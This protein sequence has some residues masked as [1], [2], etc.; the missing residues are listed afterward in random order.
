MLYYKFPTNLSQ[1]FVNLSDYTRT[2][3]MPVFKGSDDNGYSWKDN[4][5]EQYWVITHTSFAFST[6]LCGIAASANSASLPRKD[7][8]LFPLQFSQSKFFIVWLLMVFYTIQYQTNYNIEDNDKYVNQKGSR[9]I[10]R[11][12]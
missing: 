4:N 10:L 6:M 2:L 9:K 1:V 5:A 12:I 3:L 11:R 7:L 8:L